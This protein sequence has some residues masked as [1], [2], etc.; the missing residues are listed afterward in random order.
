MQIA[1]GRFVL[2]TFVGGRSWRTS[3]AGPQFFIFFALDRWCR[4]STANSFGVP[5]PACR[6]LRPTPQLPPDCRGDQLRYWAPQTC[7]L[8]CCCEC[9]RGFQGL[10]AQL[11]LPPHTHTL[12]PPVGQHTHTPPGRPSTHAPPASPQEPH[13]PTSYNTRNNASVPLTAWCWGSKPPDAHTHSGSLALRHL[14]TTQ[15]P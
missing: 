13:N 8:G 1:P 6:T 4:P 3:P 9:P 11:T 5:Q 14:T 2:C 7:G 10:P 15:C 12:P